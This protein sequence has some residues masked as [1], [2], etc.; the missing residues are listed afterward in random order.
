MA[1]KKQRGKSAASTPPAGE[2]EAA[3]ELPKKR[4]PRRR[5]GEAKNAEN[6]VQPEEEPANEK[7]K[8]QPPARK[9]RAPRINT[10]AV[11]AKQEEDDNK[12][13]QAPPE[14]KKRKKTTEN[15]ERVDGL[16]IFSEQ[17]LQTRADEHLEKAKERLRTKY[18]ISA[19]AGTLTL[20]YKSF[21]DALG[22]PTANAQLFFEW[23]Y[24]HRSDGQPPSGKLPIRVLCKHAMY[25]PL[26]PPTRIAYAA[27]V[28]CREREGGTDRT[29]AM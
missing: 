17:T 8:E 9:R 25:V 11:E 15:V 29:R 20:R 5:V 10:C 2:A 23:Q 4:A 28:T 24:Q 6:N 18:G 12:P 3:A 22:S 27:M 26:L 14:E 13:V 16:R 1:P 7:G 19:F 21:E